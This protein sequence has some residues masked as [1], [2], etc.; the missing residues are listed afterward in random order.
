MRGA[1]D[2][3]LVPLLERLNN[4]INQA[5]SQL[6]GATPSA[7]GGGGSGGGDDGASLRPS[8]FGDAS[9]RSEARR[10]ADELRRAYFSF[11]LALVT[12]DSVQLLRGSSLELVL[13]SLLDGLACDRCRTAVFVRCLP[14]QRRALLSAGRVCSDSNVLRAA[15]ASVT[16]LG[17][18]ARFACGARCIDLSFERRSTTLAGRD[19]RAA[20]RRRVG[21]C[22]LARF[23]LLRARARRR[24][25]GRHSHQHCAASLDCSRFVCCIR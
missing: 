15:A 20:G 7:G 4:E 3:L 6:A 22:R 11:L 1:L 17:K 13:S 23:V 19:W 5:A 8:C 10:E 24:R 2:Q 21:A 18:A 12:S 25:R 16:Q 14:P 9:L